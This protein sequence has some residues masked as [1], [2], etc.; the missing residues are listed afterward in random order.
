MFIA[1]D[2]DGTL[3]DS[4]SDILSSLKIVLERFGYENI[5]L[6]PELVGPSIKTII[7]T[8]GPGISEDNLQTIVLGFRKIY[9]NSG[10]NETNLYPG[11]KDLLI[12]SKNKGYPQFI[13]TNKPRIATLKIVKK[14]KIESFFEKI[15]TPDMNHGWYAKS[16][17]LELLIKEN[18]FGLNGIMIGDK[19]GDIIAAHKV[20]I[21]PIAV[22]WGYGDYDEL[23]NAGPSKI[24]D[25]TIELMN[26]ITHFPHHL[27]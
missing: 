24:V 20:N 14:L 11:L 5:T 13:V 18:A 21:T 8:V 26:V 17:L 3:I 10:F 7:R 19:A 23:K 16:E 2:M 25:T 15:Y 22:N 27:S 12:K 4:S 6:K 9:D 1:Y